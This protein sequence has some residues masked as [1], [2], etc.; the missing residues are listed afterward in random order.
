M[1]IGYPVVIFAV[2]FSKVDSLF[3]KEHKWQMKQ[4][5]RRQRTST[6][7]AEKMFFFAFFR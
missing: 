5:T 3:V 6:E 1:I 2:F 7:T 4:P